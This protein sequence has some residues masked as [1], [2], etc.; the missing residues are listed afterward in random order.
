MYNNTQYR[1]YYLRQLTKNKD[2]IDKLIAEKKEAGNVD[3][4]EMLKIEE[5]RFL[6]PLFDDMFGF[7]ERFKSPW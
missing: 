3:D 1:D 5:Q 2:K 4:A 7:N 6:S